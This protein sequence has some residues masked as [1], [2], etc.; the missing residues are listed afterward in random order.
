MDTKTCIRCAKPQPLDFFY[1]NKNTCR[2]CRAEIQRASRNRK[3]GY[4]R[5]A[6]LK[7]RYG[8]T[9]EEYESIL[10][11]QNFACAICEVEI[12]HALEYKTDRSVA[13]DHNHDTGE[14]RGILCSKCNLVLG[15]AR[16]NTEILYKSIVY[17]SERGTYTPKETKKS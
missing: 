4:H 5:R 7:H 13:V 14:V 17:L 9:P 16:E 10:I 2:P 3:P 12:S 1:A 11:Q 6:N 15:H 8:I